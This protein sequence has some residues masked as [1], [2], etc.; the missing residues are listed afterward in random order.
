MSKITLTP[1][2]SGTGTFT[3]QSPATDTNRTF[4]LPDED[5][6]LSVGGG[7]GLLDFVATGDIANGAV[8]GLRADGTVSTATPFSGTAEVF[9][10]NRTDYISA[11]YDTNANKV[12]VFW[13]DWNN[14]QDLYASVGTVSG[15]S[16]SFETRVKV[17]DNPSYHAAAA[18]D[19]ISNK[20][21]LLYYETTGS[22]RARVITLTGTTLSI[23][24]T[25]TLYTNAT[26]ATSNIRVA[27]DT[28]TGKVV[29][30]YTNN[31][32]NDKLQVGTISGTTISWGSAVSYSSYGYNN[33]ID[34]E[35]EPT[36]GKF[37]LVYRP[38]DNNITYARVGTVSGSSITLGTAVLFGASGEQRA[39]RNAIS[40]N[41]GKVVIVY[42][43]VNAS[44]LSA[45]VGTISGTSISFGTP[46]NHSTIDAGGNN[47]ATYYDAGVSKTFVFFRENSLSSSFNMEI[48]ISGTSASFSSVK[49]ELG[50]D[51]LYATAV[52]DEDQEKAVL[53]SRRSASPNDGYG[54]VIDNASTIGG[55]VGLASEAISDGATGA[56][57][58][59]SGTNESQSGLSVAKQYYLQTDGTISPNKT[60]DKVGVA[61]SSTSILLT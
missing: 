42:D 24:S 16:I 47:L 43:N 56:V 2:A 3:I 4:T 20:I 15:T 41:D 58:V 57:T 53:F 32:P 29:A 6:E 5:G 40:I 17:E 39:E 55:Y 60:D 27:V 37:V 7:A 31:A 44:R 1:N 28:T 35:F 51:G 8:V 54:Q 36:S 38:N 13:T 22:I 11:V 26:Q 25:S 14:G 33:W 45:V 10:S 50:L 21:V 48:E 19:P 46:V 49:S 30:M 59:T 18:F 61:L 9:E 52:Y 12:V 34:I 23:G